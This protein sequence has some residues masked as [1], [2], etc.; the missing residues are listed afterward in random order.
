MCYMTSYPAIDGIH[1]DIKLIH[2]VEGRRDDIGQSHDEAHRSIT[3][4]SSRQTLHVFDYAPP[5]AG[6][7]IHVHLQL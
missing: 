3:A 5:V 4:L 2:T 1:E 6:A 7:A